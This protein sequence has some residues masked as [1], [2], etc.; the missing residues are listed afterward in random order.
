MHNLGIQGNPSW[1]ILLS[2]LLVL[3]FQLNHYQD[4]GWPFLL[5]CHPH[6]PICTIVLDATFSSRAP[7]REGN[8]L[9]LNQNLAC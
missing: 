7:Y 9:C 6:S 8:M 5:L 2:L 1:A 4:G 3:S